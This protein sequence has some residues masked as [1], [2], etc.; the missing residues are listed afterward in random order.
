MQDQQTATQLDKTNPNKTF[1]QL[2]QE[3]QAKGYQGS[4]AYKK[5]INSA[6]KSNE[7]VNAQL[8]SGGT[9]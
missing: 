3:N 5:I 6:Q 1:D 9:N 8:G 4:E 7:A 2:V